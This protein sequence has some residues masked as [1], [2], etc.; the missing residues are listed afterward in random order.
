METVLWVLGVA[1][2][3]NITLSLLLF[4]GVKT[5]I[6]KLFTMV[7]ALP[8]Q[9][10]SDFEKKQDV[11]TCDI[12]HDAHKEKHVF[13]NELNVTAHDSLKKDIDGVAVIARKAH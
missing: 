8:L 7:E 2:S 11:K 3:L 6:A 1:I 4:K 13:E 12:Y 9:L 5:E 10:R